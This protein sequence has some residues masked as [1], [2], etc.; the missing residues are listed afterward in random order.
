VG[1]T[2]H[3]LRF[4]C[5]A[6]NA[7]LVFDRT[8]T[9]GRQHCDVSAPRIVR[10]F[11]DYGVEVPPGVIEL[12]RGPKYADSVLACLG[13]NQ[14]ES[15]DNSPYES[16]S[17][18][19]DLNQPIPDEWHEQHDLLYD[20]GSLE[21]IFHLPHALASYMQ[22]VRVG[23]HVVVHT[24]AN[25]WCGHGFY[26]LS[27]ELFYRVFS[28]ENGFSVKRMIMFENYEHA[29]AY[30]VPD[31]T[32]I[33]SRI[34]LSNSWVGVDLI[35]LARREG[36]MPLFSRWPQ[37]SDY[38]SR[39]AA[40]DVAPSPRQPQTPAELPIHRRLINAMKERWPALVGW[41]HWLL[42]RVPALTRSWRRSRSAAY[43]KSHSLGAQPDRY[44][45]ESHLPGSADP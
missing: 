40:F 1:M 27:P 13:A 4:L 10:M 32:S 14:V 33:R 22:L 29:P 24:M 41:K 45:Q 17:R 2:W 39:W 18:S 26:Q 44:V 35:V 23:G 37:Q 7:G 30:E 12:A 31:P 21:H 9:I 34:E 3:T 42:Y 25:N 15:I 20:G 36:R 6:R 16:A 43:H 8:V 5:E 38:A 11:A 19:W 28:E